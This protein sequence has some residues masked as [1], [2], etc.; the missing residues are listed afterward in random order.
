MAGKYE[1]AKRVHRGLVEKREGDV[2]RVRRELEGV[3]G[4]KMED[5]ER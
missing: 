2:D 1:I 5:D 4:V 3:W